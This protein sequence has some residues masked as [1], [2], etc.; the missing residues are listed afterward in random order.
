MT[1]SMALELATDGI[2]VNCVCPGTVDTPIVP[3]VATKLTDDLDSRAFD[4]MMMM[5]PG[6]IPPADIAAAIAYLASP[7]AAFMTGT[8]LA[9]DGGMG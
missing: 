3:E 8:V 1:R 4:R 2:R 6:M 7:A 5:L 9:L